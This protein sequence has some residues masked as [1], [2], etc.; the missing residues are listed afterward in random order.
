VRVEVEIPHVRAVDEHRSFRDVE[1]ALVKL[2]GEV[3]PGSTVTRF[4]STGTAQ[5]S[6]FSSRYDNVTSRNSI[7]PAIR[8]ESTASSGWWM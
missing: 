2:I 5:Q 3:V 6:A 8:P 1:E 4:S 7:R